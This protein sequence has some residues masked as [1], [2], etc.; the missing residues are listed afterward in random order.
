MAA[1]RLLRMRSIPIPIMH[2]I[3]LFDEDDD[4]QSKRPNIREQL[5]LYEDWI[6]GDTECIF[7]FDYDKI[8]NCGDNTIIVDGVLGTGITKPV[9]GAAMEAIQAMNE[10]VVG[11]SSSGSRSVRILSI[12]MP[13]GLNHVSGKPEGMAVRATWTLNLHMLKFGQLTEEAKEYI[14]E[15]WSA[16]TSL[17][18]H[19][20]G[21][22]DLVRKFRQLYEKGPIVKVQYG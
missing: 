22:E 18:Y 2:L 15:L 7:P 21:G 11:N 3:V 12:D 4:H 16:E 20:F 1:A 10:A 5:Q 14:G 8:R 13:S 9:R 17:G 6:G 19:T